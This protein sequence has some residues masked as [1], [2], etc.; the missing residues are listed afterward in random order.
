ML[1]GVNGW[2][3]E[4]RPWAWVA[5]VLAG[6]GQLFL[7]QRERGKVFGPD[8]MLHLPNPDRVTTVTAG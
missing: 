4:G 3:G 2:T 5:A 1:T 6:L 8:G 7:Y